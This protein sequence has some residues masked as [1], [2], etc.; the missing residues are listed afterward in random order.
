MSFS[1]SEEIKVTNSSKTI[2]GS[3][4]IYLH[5]FYN[6]SSGILTLTI[7]G[8]EV[9][10]G[11]T[12][13]SGS[14]ATNIATPILIPFYQSAVFEADGVSCNIRAIVFYF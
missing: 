9:N 1:K 4:F 14:Y 3:G 12:V 13:A 10:T 6:F 8:I 7:D 5:R 2:S 11:E